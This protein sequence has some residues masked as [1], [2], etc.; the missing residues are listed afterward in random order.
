[1]T[2][3]LPETKAILEWG[4]KP[5]KTPMARAGLPEEIADIIV[6][7]C[8]EEASFVTG[9]TWTVDGGYAVY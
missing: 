7:L 3:V 5:D 8:T 4:T 9:S 1:M 2:N 6:F